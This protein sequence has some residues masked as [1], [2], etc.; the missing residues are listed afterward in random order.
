[1]RSA[2]T[3]LREDRRV[4]TRLRLALVLAAIGCAG[5]GDAFHAGPISYAR[6]TKALDEQLKDKPKLR[7]AVAK[8]LSDLYGSS[9]R[10]MKVP[11]GAPLLL[12]GAFLAGQYIDGDTSP[13]PKP[14]RARYLDTSL[15]KEVTVEGGYSLYR[16]H[17]LHCHGVSGDGAGPTAEFLWP[18][19]RDYRKGIFKFTST[20]GPKP[21][22]DDLRKTIVQGIQNSSMP[23]F[24]ALM[25]PDEIEQVLDYM[26][27]LTY[28]G[29]TELGLINEVSVAEDNEAETALSAD[30]VQTIV[31]NIFESWK[32]A[33]TEILNPPVRRTPTSRES[34]LRGRTLFLGLTTEKLQCSGCHGPRAIGNGTNFVPE[35]V[36]DAIVFRG[37]KITD[38][39]EAMQ[40]LWKEGSLDDWGNP[41][42]PAN[43]NKGLYKGG[44]RPIDIYWRIAKGINGAKM[45][46]HL[47][48]LKPEQIWDLV[49]FV[50]A[51]PYQPELL[52]YVPESQTP[53]PAPTVATR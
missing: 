33:P 16:R 4:T 39:P 2:E 11:K 5:C 35:E 31:N 49:N 23:S 14:K 18:R 41:L 43:L 34:V 8:S 9:P 22:R 7:A 6:N 20:T 26:L 32:N 21:T 47:T 53:P 19:P 17:C 3:V 48:A 10:S 28:R 45:P 25:T 37:G 1:L 40:K 12:N 51:L 38:Y 29:E 46:S 52:R 27:F 15:G 13:P 30:T 50:L 42:R 24:D 36:F 44:R